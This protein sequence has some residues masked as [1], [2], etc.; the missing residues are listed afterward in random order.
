MVGLANRRPWIIHVSA[1]LLLLVIHLTFAAQMRYPTVF[2]DEIVYLGFARYFSGVEHIV[3]LAGGGMGHFGYALFLMP[4][5]WTASTFYYQYHLVL[6]INALLMSSVYLSLYF[7]L[8]RLTRLPR[9]ACVAIAFITGLY[10][11]FI[12]FTNFAVA[13]NVFVPLYLL[14]LVALYQLLE[15]QTYW[16]ATL[17]GLAGGMSYMAHTRGSSVLL[18]AATIIIILA[19]GGRL[20]RRPALVSLAILA[21]FYFATQRE[22]GAECSSQPPPA[23]PKTTRT[24]VRQ[25]EPRRSP[26]QAFAPPVNGL[27]QDILA[28]PPSHA[29]PA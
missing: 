9:L 13:D 2:Y 8:S 28:S 5:F 22:L 17:L 1:Y 20:P 24:A 12:L 14:V 26:G 10:P 25:A 3:N 18:A 7:L 11:S 19:A 21:V 15:T 29:Q 16:A 4:A 6:A 23:G 27:P